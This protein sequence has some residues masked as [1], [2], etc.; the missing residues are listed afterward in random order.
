M[1]SH[2]TSTQ[3]VFTLYSN[4][5]IFIEQTFQL[6]KL[7]YSNKLINSFMF[8]EC[9]TYKDMEWHHQILAKI[10][11]KYN[12][13]YKHIQLFLIIPFASNFDAKIRHLLYSKLLEIC[14]PTTSIT[15]VQFYHLKIKVLFHSFSTLHITRNTSYTMTAIYN[16]TFKSGRLKHTTQRVLII[17]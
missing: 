14:H 12:Y 10:I 4:P 5:N 3:I 9:L 6:P 11:M 1:S 17:T 15:I 7:Y 16:S 13:P 2:S 8:K